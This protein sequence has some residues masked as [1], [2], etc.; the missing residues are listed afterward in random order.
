LTTGKLADD[1]EKYAVFIRSAKFENVG[2]KLLRNPCNLGVLPSNKLF[3]VPLGD[4]QAHCYYRRHS[5][6]SYSY[7]YYYHHHHH[8]HH[9]FTAVAKGE[10]KLRRRFYF[11]PNK[12]PILKPLSKYYQIYPLELKFKVQISKISVPQ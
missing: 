12:N 1:S 7:Y 6:D 10:E 2:W 9:H 5:V 8:H 3:S 11:E 4:L